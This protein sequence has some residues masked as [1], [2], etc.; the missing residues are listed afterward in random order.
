MDTTE[1]KNSKASVRK[2]AD[3]IK[4]FRCKNLIAVIE[5][6]TDIKNI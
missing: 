2:R 3:A 6:P 5:D 1:A 4:D